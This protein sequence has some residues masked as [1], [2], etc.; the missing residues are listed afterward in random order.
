MLQWI[1]DLIR[2][3][4]F[5]RTLTSLPIA[6]GAYVAAGSSE[7]SLGEGVLVLLTIIIGAFVFLFIN[8]V[9]H[10]SVSYQS[11]RA[12]ER[13][14]LFSGLGARRSFLGFVISSI[15][16]IYCSGQFN[17]LTF[18]LS[19]IAIGMLS[20]YVLSRT[21]WAW[22]HCLLGFAASLLVIGPHVAV[23]NTITLSAVVG[24]LA[25][26]LWIA[27]FDILYSLRNVQAEESQG[28]QSVPIKY[29]AGWALYAA[30]TLHFLAMISWLS[31]GVL[32]DF[33]DLFFT[34]I[35][36]FSVLLFYSYKQTS[37]RTHFETIQWFFTLHFLL[38]ISFAAVAVIQPLLLSD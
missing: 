7:P 32:V 5:S 31:Y 30:S 20:I 12:R 23:E 25:L 19:P 3:L 8:R 6:I 33:G 4:R 36:L 34:V 24:G 13:E 9:Y 10:L 16:F 35:L 21:R 37:D 27:G 38:S 28:F 29:G 11:L 22:N 1:V 18:L 15:L 2:F 26:G 14:R 17:R